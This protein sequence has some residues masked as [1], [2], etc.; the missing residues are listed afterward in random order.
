M[1]NDDAT[2]TP[3][4]Q[5][6]R[7]QWCSGNIPADASRCPRCGSALVNDDIAAIEEI[8]AREDLLLSPDPL[9]GVGDLSTTLV[10]PKWSQPS[11]ARSSEDRMLLIGLVLGVSCVVGV[12]LGLVVGPP[13][14]QQ[15]LESLLQTQVDDTSGFRQTGGII[16][17]VLGLFFGSIIGT[18]Y[19]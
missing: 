14:L 2:A 16:G 6:R 3:A 12:L 10:D 17:G 1:R 4:Q 15:G 5:I 8:T 11:P 19:R 13:L 9:N 18:I 7:C